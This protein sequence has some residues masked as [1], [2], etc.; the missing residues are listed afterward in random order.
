[1]GFALSD[2]LDSLDSQPRLLALVAR[3]KS[4][5]SRYRLERASRSPDV[6]VGLNVGREGSLALGK[7]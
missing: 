7:D 6:T 4:A 3:E 5:N 2:L 1:M